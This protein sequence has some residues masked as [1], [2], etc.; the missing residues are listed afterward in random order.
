M[1][2][3]VLSLVHCRATWVKTLT[4]PLGGDDFEMIG[5]ALAH[6]ETGG[7]GRDRASEYWRGW[8]RGLKT[9]SQP[10]LL[11]Y[12]LESIAAQKATRIARL[13]SSP[14]V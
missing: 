4:S 9:S 14:M 7:A 3:S 10:V 5:A 2:M 13:G 8:F 6:P 12:Y 1:L 11:S